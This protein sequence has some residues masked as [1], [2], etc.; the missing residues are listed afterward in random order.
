MLLLLLAFGG[1]AQVTVRQPPEVLLAD[2][3]EPEARITTNRELA[4]AYLAM[5]R[6][7]RLCNADKSALRD[8]AAINN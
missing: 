6:A 5:R 2:C 8:W 1:C 3:A 4:E 7:L